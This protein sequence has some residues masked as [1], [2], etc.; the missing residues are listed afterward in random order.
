M[1]N[2]KSNKSQTVLLVI[3]IVLTLILGGFILYDKII[4]KPQNA[5]TEYD[6]NNQDNDSSKKEEI[7][8]EL[9]SITNEIQLVYDNAYK[10]LA[11]GSGIIDYN[12]TD[13]K[14]GEEETVGGVINVKAYKLDFTKLEPYFTERAINFIKS[15]FTDTPY[16]HKDENYYIFAEENKYSYDKKEFLNTIFGQTNQSKRILKVNL[17]DNNTIL[18]TSEKTSSLKLD[19]Y[20]VFKKINNTWKI[21]MFE[22]F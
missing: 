13:I 10:T 9:P 20:I 3:F 6:N 16:G 17:Y 21:D 14:V 18:A 2:Q 4:S 12:T 5:S 8:N 19:E 15:Y 11:E 22:E 1:I 7:S